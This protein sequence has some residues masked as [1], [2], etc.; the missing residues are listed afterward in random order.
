MGLD[1]PVSQGMHLI[2]VYLIGVNLIGVDLM[3]GSHAW[4]SC[5]D[6]IGIHLMGVYLLQE[7]LWIISLPICV[8]SYPAREF[9]LEFA[10]LIHPDHQAT[11]S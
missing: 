9:A 10:P 3:R 1:G 11:P 2:G 5:V 8:R 6:L 4:I 7:E